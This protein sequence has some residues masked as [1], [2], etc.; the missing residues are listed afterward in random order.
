AVA[1]PSSERRARVRVRTP[2]GAQLPSALHPIAR[3]RAQR[4]A[5]IGAELSLEI[6]GRGLTCLVNAVILPAA[7]DIRGDRVLAVF[8]DITEAARLEREVARQ[9]ARLEAIVHLVDEGIF[10]VNDEAR[11]VFVNDA[12]RR[13]VAVRRGRVVEGGRGG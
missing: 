2:D 6:D 9:A 7:D 8:H 4:Q 10:V 5:V 13:V 11:L 1:R 3:A 12:G